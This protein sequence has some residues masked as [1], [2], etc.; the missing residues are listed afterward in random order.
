[1]SLMQLL[2][3]G[4]SLGTIKD[5]PSRYKMTQQNL[6][7][8]FGRPSGAESIV[9]SQATRAEAPKVEHPQP[10]P[11]DQEKMPMTHKKIVSKAGDEARPDE[12]SPEVPKAAFPS[13]RWTRIRNPFG[14]RKTEEIP[15]APAQG[16]LSLDMVK[17]VRNDLND[18]DLEVVLARRKLASV[19][20]RIR[21]PAQQPEPVGYLW[22]RLSARLFRTE[23]P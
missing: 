1:M 17:P 20:E 12:T 6:L 13:G 2:T 16:E 15:A 18:A 14:A 3:V 8:K 7:P 23:Q 21:V 4:R 10:G 11:V 9:A 22:S 5:Q 19:E